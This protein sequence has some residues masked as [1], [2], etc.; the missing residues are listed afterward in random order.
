MSE[1]LRAKKRT[2]QAKLRRKENA[3]QFHIRNKDEDRS[4]SEV[5]DLFEEYQP[6]CKELTDIH[7]A[8]AA[9]IENDY[10]FDR[11]EERMTGRQLEF[12]QFQVTVKNY[13]AKNSVSCN[14]NELTRDLEKM[15]EELRAKRTAAD[16]KLAR[17]EKAIQFHIDEK[18]PSS[19]V[20][21]LF[22]EY[23]QL[24]K[25]LSDSHDAYAVTVVGNKVIFGIEEEWM[26][27]RQLEFFT[28]Q[29]TIKN[30]LAK[31]SVPCNSNKAV[32][33]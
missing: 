4:S 7:D 32:I 30:Y 8:Y 11:E 28:F 23:L 5:N 9:T 17:K 29:V 20:S 13:L 25:E 19:E 21:D 33:V 24:C 12:L 1:E 22:E 16:A 27:K 15:S 6:L 31:N 26:T 10:Q 14:P 3:I 18:R 2:A